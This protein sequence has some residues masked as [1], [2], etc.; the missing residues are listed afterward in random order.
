MLCAAAAALGLGDN[1]QNAEFACKNMTHLV[2]QTSSHDIDPALMVSLIHHESRWKPKTIS[3]SNACGLTQVVPKW[4][5]GRAS[6]GKK[7]T[8]DDLMD[9]TT[10]ITAGSEILSF[11]IRSYGR[12]SIKIGLCGYNAGYRCKGSNPNESGM[13]YSRKVRKTQRQIT[14]HINRLKKR[15]KS[16]V[17]KQE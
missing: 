6:A 14:R 1:P 10:S 17:D 5:G 16:N 4:T 11:W 7:Y 2:E 15:E 12:G 9:A 8:C 3:R 13:N